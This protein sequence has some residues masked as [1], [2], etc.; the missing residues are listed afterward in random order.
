MDKGHVPIQGAFLHC[1]YCGHQGGYSYKF[2]ARKV[3]DVASRERGMK[4]QGIEQR[5][6]KEW[7]SG[8]ANPK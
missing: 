2:V 5:A 3:R 1:G 6:E 8:D 7:T 4:S